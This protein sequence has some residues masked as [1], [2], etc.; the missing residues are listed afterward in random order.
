MSGPFTRAD[1][2]EIL[3]AIEYDHR[4]GTDDSPEAYELVDAPGIGI[5]K[6]LLA[7]ADALP[8]PEAQP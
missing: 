4:H 3:K 7:L 2:T 6:N 5:F 1:V 8:E